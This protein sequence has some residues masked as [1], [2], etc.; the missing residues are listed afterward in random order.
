[1]QPQSNENSGGVSESRPLRRDPAWWQPIPMERW[2]AIV[3]AARNI[4]T[5]WHQVDSVLRTNSKFQGS[6]FPHF[7]FCS[8][9]QTNQ[10]PLPN[11]ETETQQ[12]LLLEHLLYGCSLCWQAALNSPLC[13]HIVQSTASANHA[14]CNE[15]E[16]F[17]SVHKFYKH[18]L[19]SL[20]AALSL[21]L[22]IYLSIYVILF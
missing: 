21:N 10:E 13:H 2:P 19:Q 22:S 15:V 20:P 9:F 1:M 18:V 16:V 6:K 8:G 17:D 14:W 4:S 5:V 3:T 7:R 11:P 12:S